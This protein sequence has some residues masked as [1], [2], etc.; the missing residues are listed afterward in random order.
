MP[1]EMQIE[2]IKR[3][4]RRLNP[5]LEDAE[6]VPGYDN[7]EQEWEDDLDS[8][9]SLPENIDELARLYP[10]VKWKAPEKRTRPN[11]P[12]RWKDE[13]WYAGPKGDSYKL[14]EIVVVKRQRI[15]AKGH[16]YT[17]G[18]IQVTLDEKFIGLRAK[19]SVFVQGAGAVNQTDK[20]VRSE[21]GKKEDRATYF[22]C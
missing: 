22:K 15:K 18:R 1:L 16:I 11:K 19:V 13:D 2:V 8:S 4:L 17:R 14:R 10:K 5:W 20:L 12:L 9:L 3:N 7:P 6:L 21:L